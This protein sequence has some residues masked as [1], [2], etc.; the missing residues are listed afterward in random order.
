MGAAHA[1]LFHQSD[2]FS[3]AHQRAGKNKRV[4]AALLAV[5]TVHLHIN[6]LSVI[7]QQTRWS[8]GPSLACCVCVYLALASLANTQVSLIYSSCA[9]CKLMA[10][11][12]QC[13]H[14]CSLA[15]SR[16]RARACARNDNENNDVQ[17]QPRTTMIHVA[18]KTT[19]LGRRVGLVTHARARKLFC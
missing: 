17:P 13:N 19:R 6:R 16:A 2:S 18:I 8:L 5:I 15:I 9:F 4:T 1:T 3:A 14:F 11:H 12:E 10:L 7:T